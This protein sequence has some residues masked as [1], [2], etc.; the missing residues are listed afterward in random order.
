MVQLRN[1]TTLTEKE[2]ERE[3]RGIERQFTLMR[4]VS[5]KANDV[6]RAVNLIESELNKK[7]KGY[8]KERYR[9]YKPLYEGVKKH[10]KMAL[11]SFFF[12]MIR[13]VTLMYAAMFIDE[14]PWLQI[15][16]F[17]TFSIWSL[18]YIGYTWPNVDEG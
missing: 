12:L 13:R 10:S 1:Q 9:K 5:S 18:S 17:V 16:L 7:A 3:S 2:K 15:F 14:M 4:L 6:I 11:M 8:S